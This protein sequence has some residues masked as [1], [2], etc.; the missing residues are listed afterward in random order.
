[1]GTKIEAA[2]RFLAGRG[3]EVIITL[4]E[5]ARAALDGK[6]GPLILR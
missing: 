5:T 1:M 2:I 6:L 3:R 4:P